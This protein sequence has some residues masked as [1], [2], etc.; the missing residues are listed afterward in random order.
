MNELVVPPPADKFPD[1]VISAVP[2]KRFG[3]LLQILLYTSLAVNLIL[4]LVPEICEAIFPPPAFSTR[5]LF[6]DPAFTANELLVPFCTPPVVLVAVIVKLPV[7]VIVNPDEDNIPAVNATDVP[8][9]DDT[10]PVE[11]IST[12]PV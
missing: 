3:P 1:D 2:E 7:F 9:P 10:V 5:I 12:F 4:K 8:S 6:I 11:V